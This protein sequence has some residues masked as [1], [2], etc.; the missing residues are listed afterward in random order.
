MADSIARE[1]V[2]ALLGALRNA[3]VDA[4][5]RL[6]LPEFRQ[7]VDLPNGTIV[8]FRRDQWVANSYPTARVVG[9]ATIVSAAAVGDFLLTTYHLRPDDSGVTNVV[10]LETFRDR[11]VV[12]E[13]WR[14]QGGA[15]QLAWRSIG[16]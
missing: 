8:I 4:L 11:I 12:R 14:R 2:S 1:Q 9:S 13:V 7:E 16:L 6:T 10:G 15:F 3:D 5:M